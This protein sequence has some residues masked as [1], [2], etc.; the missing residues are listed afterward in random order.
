MPSARE[1]SVVSS[2]SW[3]SP[4]IGPIQTSFDP[5]VREK[6]KHSYEQSLVGLWGCSNL[7][8]VADFHFYPCETEPASRALKL[9]SVIV[10][11]DLHRRSLA[12]TLVAQS[13]ID[14]ISNSSRRIV[15][16]YAY[17][18]HPATV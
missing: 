18:V 3:A 2:S 6:H 1:A 16:V 10:N 8:A 4:E 14:L 11:G 12:S 9:D 7:C 15:S 17:S 13:L 5:A